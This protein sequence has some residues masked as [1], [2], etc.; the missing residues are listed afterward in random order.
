MILSKVRKS[1][2]YSDKRT[3]TQNNIPPYKR[4]ELLARKR[5]DILGNYLKMSINVQKS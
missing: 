3:L 2:K 4:A 1:G 5:N